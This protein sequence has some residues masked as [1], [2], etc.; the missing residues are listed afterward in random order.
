M[1]SSIERK[2]VVIKLSDPWDLGETLHWKPL[3]ALVFL[4]DNTT[5]PSRLILR[6]TDPFEYKRIPCEYFVATPRH[7]GGV[8]TDLLSRKSVFCALTRIPETRLQTEDPFDLAWWRGGP[9][10]VGELEL[11]DQ[12]T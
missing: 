1:K 4:V 8:L 12:P 11:D 2:A 10:L 5:T 6:L 3:R 7:E 9:A